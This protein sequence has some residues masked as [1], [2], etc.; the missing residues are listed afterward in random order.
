[1]NQRRRFQD[2]RSE[3]V[4]A[5][6]KTLPPAAQHELLRELRRHKSPAN[7]DLHPTKSKARRLQSFP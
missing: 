2:A 6:I 7:R 3:V 1:M 4:W 5:A